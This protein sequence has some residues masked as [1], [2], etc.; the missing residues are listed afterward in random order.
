MII[1]PGLR[2]TPEQALK[3]SWIKRNKVQS[4]FKENNS[5]IAGSAILEDLADVIKPLPSN[6]RE[7][8]KANRQA[9]QLQK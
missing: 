2:L 5:S 6:R 3:H 4:M 7:R 1:D 8:A 9:Q